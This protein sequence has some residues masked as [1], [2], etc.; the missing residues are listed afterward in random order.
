MEGNHKHSGARRPV[1]ITGLGVLSPIGLSVAEVG[2]SLASAR[3][4]IAMMEAPPLKKS[5]AAGTVKQTFED[6]FTKLELP[7]LD[8]CQH[9]AILA[10][11][12]AIHDA[13]LDK[14]SEYGQRAG[15][16]YGNVN[17]GIATEQAWYQQL[18]VDGKQ[19]SRPFSAMA[20]MRNGGAAQISIRHQVLGPV[21]TH[22]SACGSSG[23][24]IGDAVRAIRD[25]YL[26]VAVAGGAEAPLTASLLGVFDGTRALSAPDPEDAARTCKPFSVNRS[27]LV[28]GE[29][30]AFLVLEPE[31]RAIAR[32]AK[33]YGYVTGYGVASDGHHIGSPHPV[34]QAAAIRA[35]L[36]EAGLAPGDIDYLNAHATATNGGDVV[37]ATAIAS[38]FGEGA[39][40]VPV[41]STKSVH[42]HLL[43]AASA[44]ELLITVV[45]M[46]DSIVPATAHLDQPD[47][48]CALNHVANTP[49]IGSPIQRAMSFSCGFGGTNV[50]L[51][52]SKHREMPS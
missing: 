37:E 25:G 40:S 19:A 47:P 9:L 11:H 5:F 50:A 24:A 41:S 13:G 2:E 52:I 38:V 18:L 28:L 44:L 23:I 26:D 22:G 1:V 43:G 27:G 51:V 4:G 14:F 45:A 16:Y 15:L 34:G 35:A 21:V 33:I 3:S 49:R 12:D 32:G 30:A 39:G 6:R 42:G 29:G 7:Y 20:I 46:K 31:D 48:K 36:D 10:A 8:R 17:G